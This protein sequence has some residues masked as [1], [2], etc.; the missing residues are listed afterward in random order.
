MSDVNINSLWRNVYIGKNFQNNVISL[1]DVDIYSCDIKI[2]RGPSA[3]YECNR[4]FYNHRYYS[5]VISLCDFIFDDLAYN[6]DAR[7]AS[8]LDM[9][10]KDVNSVDLFFLH[11]SP[12]SLSLNK[13]ATLPSE[14]IKLFSDPEIRLWVGL[15]AMPAWYCSVFGLGEGATEI[16]E[17]KFTQNVKDFVD[18]QKLTT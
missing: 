13:D 6:M 8:V 11:H 15:S 9:C 17:N 16:F 7:T 10:I 12:I 3:L 4:V 1:V 5:L 2:K 14:A 18:R